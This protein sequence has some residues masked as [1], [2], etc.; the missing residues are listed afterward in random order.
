MSDH[1]IQDTVLE[2]FYALHSH[3]ELS[4][5][6]YETTDLIRSTLRRSG[7]DIL[8]LPL[9]TGLVAAV[10]HGDRV[11]AVRA[12]IDALPIEENT[13]L[14]YRSIYSGKMHA[15]GHDFHAAAILG[16]AL[17]LKEQESSL[18]GLVKIIFQPA[19][20]APGGAGSVIETG[21]LDD[22]KTI[23]GI[24]TS[25]AFDTG[26]VALREGA[27][28][29]AVDRFRIVFRGKGTHAA[30]PNLGND[31]FII[32]AN[33]ITAVQ[34]V[35]SRNSDPFA[36]NLISIGHVEGGK[37]WN[38]I[39]EEVLLEG[40]I[41]SMNDKDRKLCQD[42][43]MKLA[44]SIAAAF[45]GMAD[46][47]WLIG[48]PAISNDKELTDF[49]REI[50]LCEGFK[51]ESAPRSLGGEDFALY[52][53]KIKGTFIQIGSGKGLPLHNPGF[54]AD[55]QAIYPA[56]VYMA[57]LAAQALEHFYDFN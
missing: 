2:V 5:E 29:A 13:D 33:F 38:V 30:H 16:T 53:Q 7:I 41:R 44:H 9:K 32:A 51:V 21:V 57:H 49:A 40:T 18:K 10:G 22:V 6:E 27:T 55:P 46:V 39:P 34:T 19:E 17:L 36:T 42:R 8:N 26:T 1:F 15:C 54:I 45:N 25:P 35:V 23:F 12:D 28:H 31:P 37:T 43:V 48:I 50:A 56:S 11:I 47:E 3:P 52:E 4:Y 20:E 24:H 14:S